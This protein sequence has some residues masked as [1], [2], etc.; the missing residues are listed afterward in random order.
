MNDPRPSQI[1]ILLAEDIEFFLKLHS[2]FL[3]RKA[4]D[5]VIVK[6]GEE[7]LG[8]IRTRR[9]HITIL[10]YHMSRLSGAQVCQQVR[11]DPTFLQ[12]PILILTGSPQRAIVDQCLAAGCDEVV[13]KSTGPGALLET[14]LR[15]LAIPV[16]ESPRIPVRISFLG[17]QE[18]RPFSAKSLDLSEGGMLIDTDRALQ[19]G[20]PVKVAFQLPGTEE[21]I[22]ATSK[23]V[24]DAGAGI[25]HRYGIQFVS[26]VEGERQAIRRFVE[27]QLPRPD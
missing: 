3:K 6:D 1:V 8:L 27:T 2:S 24:R 19:L 16:R 5:M 21:T 26:F 14:V 11:A 13:D 10:D 18:Q 20:E 9:P 12:M 25:Q 7:A 15:Y 17:T 4:V 22:D 23:I